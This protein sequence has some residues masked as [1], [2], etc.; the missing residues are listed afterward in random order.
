MSVLLSILAQCLH[1]A[2]VVAVA[3]LLAGS[4]GALSDRLG[5]REGPPM[6]R[7]WHD[8]TRLFRKEPLRAEGA[9]A[10]TRAMPLLSVILA[11][12]CVFLVPS[13]TLGMVSAPLAD[14]LTIAALFMLGRV[15]SVLVAMDAGTGE[16]GAVAAGTTRLAMAAE[17]A[18]LLAVLVL[19]LHAG[20]G[21]LDA[22]LAVRLDAAPGPA[23][24]LAI[25]AL[26]LLGWAEATRPSMQSVFSG[27]D[28]ALVRFA[29][30]LRLLAWCDLI[31]ALA[32]P[33]GMAAADT[34]PFAWGIGM[35]AW[36]SRLLLAAAI[37][38]AARVAGGADKVPA[39]LVLALALCGVATVLGLAS[40]GP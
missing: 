3:P 40:A 19:A 16:G 29:D 30:R 36:V 39:M 15:L 4:I 34:G 23:P 7:P 21:N 12:L 38:A 35:L 37:L 27:R 24:G 26:A 31:G 1:M 10:A 11:A 8:L 9:S 13:F 22:I 6:P 28:L 5:G 33:F 20:S 17:P 14:F 32:L 25:A 2:A 18:L